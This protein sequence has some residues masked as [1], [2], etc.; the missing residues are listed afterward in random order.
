VRYAWLIDPI[1]KTLEVYVLGAGRWVLQDVYAENDRVRAE[2][3][4]EAE[5]SL[6]DLWWE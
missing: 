5:I 4:Q 6:E 2:P 1:L 3:F